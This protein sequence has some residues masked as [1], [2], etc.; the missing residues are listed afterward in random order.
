M[1]KC[2]AAPKIGELRGDTHRGEAPAR[3]CGGWG[4]RRV[5]ERIQFDGFFP[6]VGELDTAFFLV[7]GWK[8]AHDRATGGRASQRLGISGRAGLAVAE[9]VA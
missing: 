7:H 5:D 3:Q 4:E 6:L 2:G 9:V 8:G 1:V